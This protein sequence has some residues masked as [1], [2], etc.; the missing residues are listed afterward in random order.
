MK[1]VLV[2]LLCVS[3][4]LGCASTSKPYKYKVCTK[5]QYLQNQNIKVA[6]FPFDND[7]Y[8]VTDLMVDDAIKDGFQ[9][10]ERAELSKV[11]NEMKLQMSGITENEK[12]QAGK[13]LNVDIIIVGSVYTEDRPY[14][15]PNLSG[16]EGLLKALLLSSM[17]SKKS[18]TYVYA[19]M[20]AIDVQTGQ[21]I[22]AAP[23][24]FIRKQ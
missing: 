12:V 13:I 22:S 14:N 19:S 9:V 2:V 18:G 23:N 6:I 7:Y 21:V 16:N 5:E 15:S 3:T 8:G 4:F 24:I 10:V 17:A 11:F 1:S 20:R